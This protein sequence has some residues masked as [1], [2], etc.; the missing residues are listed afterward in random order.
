MKD[1]PVLTRALAD[2]L[3]DGVMV[4]SESGLAYANGRGLMLLGAARAEDVIGKSLS[5]LLSADTFAGIAQQEENQRPDAP[6]AAMSGHL[7]RLDGGTVAVHLSSLPILWE[8]TPS[9]L[10]VIALGA[11]PSEVTDRARAE[12][13]R[14]ESSKIETVGMLVAGIAHEFNNNLTAVLGFSQL[15]IML[16]PADGKAH[17]HIQHV[18]TAGRKASEL[19]HQAL[20]FSRQHAEARCPLSLHAVVN[21][22]L[23]FLRSTIPSWIELRERIAATTSPIEADAVQMR[24]VLVNLI[25]DAVHAM[26][27]SGGV[28]DIEVQ[29]EEVS[30]D[31]IAPGGRI[32]A[33]RY[34]CVC[35]SDSGEITEHDATT[36]IFDP[37]LNNV[38]GGERGV[39][40]SVVHGIVSA[41]G[42]TVLVESKPGLGTT[43]AIFFP[44]LTTHASSV[45][46][47]GR[48]LGPGHNMSAPLIEESNAVGPRD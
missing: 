18:I 46:I 29:D 4:V 14:Y 45:S 19:I 30:A 47:E 44:A 31:R 36:R 16:L 12:A 37:S 13:Y 20:M 15:A 2:R 22:S 26:R 21:D 42:G 5:S 41:H 34:V 10:L 40:L 33:G 1:A 6:V 48:V 17:R 43:I 28:L 32:R 7:V 23:K 25:A 39:G 11:G 3:S 27:R 8:G 24:Q 38:L 35:V 9:R